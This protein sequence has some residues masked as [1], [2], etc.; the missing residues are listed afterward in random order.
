[1]QVYDNIAC[2]SA[3][4]A[5]SHLANKA[6]VDAAVAGNGT[7]SVSGDNVVSIPAHSLISCEIE[8]TDDAHL[9]NKAYVDSAVANAVPAT[10]IEEPAALGRVVIVDTLSDAASHTGTSLRDAISAVSVGGS[11][12]IKFSVSGTITLEQGEIIIP[13]A[14][15]AIDGEDKIT[16]SGGNVSRVFSMA[17][18]GTL[19]LRALVITGGNGVG[20]TSSEQYGGAIL[21]GG[22]TRLFA[23]GVTF[24]ANVVSGTA[25]NCNGGAVYLNGSTGARFVNCS[26]LNNTVST[27]GNTSGGG[28][29]SG[30]SSA[31]FAVF[32]NCY[33][34]NNS[35]TSGSSANGGAVDFSYPVLINCEFVQNSLTAN[36]TSGGALRST[37]R[38]Y[39]AGCVF[40]LND[41]GTTKATHVGG[42]ICASGILS[43]V[44]DCEFTGNRA[45]Y[46]GGVATSGN[47]SQFYYSRLIRCKFD[48]NYAPSSGRGVAIYAYYQSITIE[49]CEFVNHA[50]GS[51]SGVVY[52]YGYT[53]KVFH[54]TINRC[55]FTGNSS[56]AATTGLVYCANLAQVYL[57]NT[58]FTANSFTASSGNHKCVYT[59]G[60]SNAFIYN[61]T[62]TN[63]TNKGGAFYAASGGVDIYNSVEYGNGSASG[64][65]TN[66]TVN[67]S[68][69]LSDQSESVGRDIAYDST[70]PLFAADGFTPVANSQ[71]IDK[72]DDTYALTEYDLNGKARVSGTKV[73]LGAVEY[74]GA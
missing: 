6:Y 22:M 32:E 54:I 12:V 2:E 55:K 62:F 29:V 19:I 16:I 68:K 20:A 18:F 13:A 60:S 63:N 1:M 51:A 48:N 37:S 56:S 71:V 69:F 7:A 53:N 34:G 50:V 35:A 31:L 67:A 45:Y 11:V 5:D 27:T 41:A 9:V 8:P 59:P 52:C 3:P 73:D 14:N 43:E 47:T 15:V 66:A 25:S 10:P 61:C 33:F 36:S 26:F 4:V 40:R 74:L 58:V 49:G 42:A 46:G 39:I 28:A 17:S 21:T 64:K 38:G 72:G 24:Q 65:G 30:S 44:V 23:R 57:Y 70:K